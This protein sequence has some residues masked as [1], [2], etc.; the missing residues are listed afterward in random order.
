MDRSK[1]L[2]YLIDHTFIFERFV[3]S[4]WMANIKRKTRSSEE[5]SDS[6]EESLLEGFGDGKLKIN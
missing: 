5:Y 2:E 1:S 6:D 3:G 4:S